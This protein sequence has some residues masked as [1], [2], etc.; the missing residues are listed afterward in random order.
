MKKRYQIDRERAVQ[1]FQ[2]QAQHSEESLQ[3][4]LPLKQVAAALQDG[5]GKGSDVLIDLKGLG[6]G[7]ARQRH[8][9]P[10]DSTYRLLGEGRGLGVHFPRSRRTGIGGECRADLPG[11]RDANTKAVRRR[12]KAGD[13]H[14]GV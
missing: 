7:G 5:V 6:N 4:A 14:P 13:F 8:V 9:Q 1:N 2:K 10:A 3:L 12:S 11:I